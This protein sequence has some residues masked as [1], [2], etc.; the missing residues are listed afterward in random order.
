MAGEILTGGVSIAF[1]AYGELYAV[2]LLCDYKS[3]LLL[4]AGENFVKRDTKA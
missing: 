2:I 3:I 1:A 4:Q